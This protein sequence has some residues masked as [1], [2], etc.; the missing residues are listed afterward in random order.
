MRNLPDIGAVA[1]MALDGE[2]AWLPLEE[3]PVLPVPMDN[4]G[5]IGGPGDF[6]WLL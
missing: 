2:G 6:P 4:T 3:Y 5:R 1:R